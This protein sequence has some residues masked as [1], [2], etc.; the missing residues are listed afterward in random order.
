[1]EI[2]ENDRVR[3]IEGKILNVEVTLMLISIGYM[4]LMLYAPLDWKY[5]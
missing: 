2:S 3:R 5:T 1:M 4:C